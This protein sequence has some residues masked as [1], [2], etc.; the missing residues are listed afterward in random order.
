M[1]SEVVS[2]GK[3]L[4]V[5]IPEYINKSAKITSFIDQL[6]EKK[7]IRILNNYSTIEEYSY[8]PWNEVARIAKLIKV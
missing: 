1:C 7:I 3:P 6:V 8:K 5:Y 4:Y 2:S